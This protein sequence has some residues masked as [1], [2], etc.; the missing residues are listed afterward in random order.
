M[1]LE[2]DK[3]KGTE[4]EGSLSEKYCTHCYGDGE[5]KQPDVTK[6]E[7]VAFVDNLMKEKDMN[8]F[9]RWMTRMMIPRLE[10]WKS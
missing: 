6:E 1:P 5:F 8:F 10:R 4:K 3:D 9:M 2:N 7:M